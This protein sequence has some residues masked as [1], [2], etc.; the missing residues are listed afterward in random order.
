[1]MTNQADKMAYSKQW[2]LGRV[3]SLNVKKQEGHSG[4]GKDDTD[5]RNK[6]RG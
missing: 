6:D 1:M 3:F 5:Q 2:D 4:S